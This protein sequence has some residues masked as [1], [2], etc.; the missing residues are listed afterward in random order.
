MTPSISK[1]S[2]R[3]R[4]IDILLVFI[5]VLNIAFIVYLD[6]SKKAQAAIP[7]GGMNGSIFWCNCSGNLVLHVNDLVSG[8]KRL[9]Y[10][11]GGTT[12]YQFGQVRAGVWMLGLWNPGGMCRFFVGKG[13][14]IYPTNGTV[15]MMGTSM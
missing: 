1:V 4:I 8:P 3:L 11:P 15:Q 10:Q 14:A 2:S 6:E 13:C 7:F 5:L 12:L 9:I